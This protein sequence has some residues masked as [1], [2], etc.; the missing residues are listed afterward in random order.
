MESSTGYTSNS[1]VTV[2]NN[3]EVDKVNGLFGFEKALGFLK[4]GR[5]VRRAEWTP[6][7]ILKQDGRVLRLYENG[8]LT[9]YPW[10]GTTSSVLAEDWQV[11]LDTYN[12]VDALAAVKAGAKVR[13]RGW[14]G[15]H[16]HLR[17][18]V[19]SDDICIFFYGNNTPGSRWHPYSYEFYAT[20]WY[21]VK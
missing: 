21:E 20:D 6:N 10:K 9:G 17:K 4:A 19:G 5:R 3:V 7:T 18:L 14:E 13:R 2:K 1:P 16:S 8:E 12:F 15:S 11:V